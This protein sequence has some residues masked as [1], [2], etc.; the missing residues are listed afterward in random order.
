MPEINQRYKE[1]CADLG[2]ATDHIGASSTSE[3]VQYLRETGRNAEFVRDRWC[4]ITRMQIDR[5]LEYMQRRAYSFTTLAPDAIHRE[6]LTKLSKELIGR[7]GNLNAVIEVPNQ[8][9]MVIA[10]DHIG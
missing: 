2:F 3:V 9:S 8:I 10:V 5:A 1:L 6:A 4:W 7:Y